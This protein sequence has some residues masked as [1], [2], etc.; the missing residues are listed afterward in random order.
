M[1]HCKIKIEAGLSQ[2]LYNK[3]TTRYLILA[4]NK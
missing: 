4:S 2:L 3:E 1:I